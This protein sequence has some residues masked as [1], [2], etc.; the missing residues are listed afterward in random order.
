[1]FIS[2]N[3]AGKL[4]GGRKANN[5]TLISCLERSRHHFLWDQR[6]NS[7]T[8]RC[9]TSDKSLSCSSAFASMTAD[10]F[11]RR[12]VSAANGKMKQNRSIKST[13]LNDVP[14]IFDFPNTHLQSSSHFLPVSPFSSSNPPSAPADI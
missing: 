6:R 13:L 4:N 2:E 8:C 1:M 7:F 14:V 12:T 3:R 9:L 11:C 5:N 10:S